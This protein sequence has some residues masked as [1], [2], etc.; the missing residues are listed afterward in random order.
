DE[1][2]NPFIAVVTSTD[3][4]NLLAVGADGG[5]MLTESDILS[6][7]TN[8]TLEIDNTT[9][10]LVYTNE[11]NDNAAISLDD[12]KKEPWFDQANVGEQATGNLQDIYQMGRVG[13]GTQDMNGIDFVTNPD[14][15]LAVAGSIVT[16]NSIYADY[17]FED[18][19]NG[20]STIND[21]YE[22]KKLEE[23]EVFIKKHRHLPGIT[24][25]N[26]LKKTDKGYSFDISK[27]TIQSLE[28]IEELYLHTIEQNNIIKAQSKEIERLKA[29][30]KS[31][32]GRLKKVE[33]LLSN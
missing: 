5:A 31:L 15:M 22:F 8:T 33:S 10:E 6:V 20:F 4:D 7:E 1:A 9:N 26:Q 25:V 28:K 18:Y 19:F 27:L 32:E 23:V 12:L 16:Q 3:A 14:V 11:D 29:E 21:T 30:Q 2:S 13:I 17:V 24:P